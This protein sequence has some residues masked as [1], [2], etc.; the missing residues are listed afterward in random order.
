MNKNIR[1][2]NIENTFALVN[3]YL[4]N[5]QINYTKLKNKYMCFIKTTKFEIIFDKIYGY[6]N[7]YKLKINVKNNTNKQINEII[8]NIIKIIS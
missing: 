1:I 2:N 3:D 7:L 5:N 6:D 8:G 4:K